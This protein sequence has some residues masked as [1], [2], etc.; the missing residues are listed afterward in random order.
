MPTER[1]QVQLAA[2]PRGALDW[3]WKRPGADDVELLCPAGGVAEAA[4]RISR[5]LS[6]AAR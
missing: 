4:E 3:Y 1:Q 6:L 2:D 5:A